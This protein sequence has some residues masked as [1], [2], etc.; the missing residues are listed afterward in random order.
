[1]ATKLKVSFGLDPTGMDLDI[2]EEVIIP[3]NVCL[4]C[5]HDS[6]L[7]I[8]RLHD[9]IK[10]ALEYKGYDTKYYFHLLKIYTL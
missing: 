2:T 7:K 4:Y 9:E 5:L 10:K 8:N 6:S 3:D 1:M